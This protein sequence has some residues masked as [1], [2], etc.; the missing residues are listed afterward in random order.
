[1]LYLV[2]TG[3]YEENIETVLE[4]PDDFDFSEAFEDLKLQYDTSKEITNPFIDYLIAY[5]G[6]KKVEYKT[7]HIQESGFIRKAGVKLV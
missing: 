4:G 1:M 3:E 5:C 6:F 7:L 2:D